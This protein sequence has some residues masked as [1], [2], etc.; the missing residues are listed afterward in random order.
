[1]RKSHNSFTLIELMV[2]MVVMGVL[3]ALAIPAFSR[4]ISGNKVD[5]LAS[6]LKLALE[7]AQSRAVTD[8]RHVALILPNRKN[9]DTDEKS[10]AK[11][12]FGGCRMAFVKH[13][14][15][16]TVDED[17]G[18]RSYAQGWHFLAWVPDSAWQPAI[19][20]V[21]LIKTSSQSAGDFGDFYTDG[22]G[23]DVTKTIAS[24]NYDGLQAI[25]GCDDVSSA[26]NCAV[27]FSPYG[28][29]AGGESLRLAVAEAER[30]G[31][32]FVFPSQDS[33][34]NPTDFRVLEVN[35]FTGRVKHMPT[36]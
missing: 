12:E 11:S 23:L 13:Q 4:M 24:V 18:V 16:M 7:Q 34:G 2:V 6:Q 36:Y 5:Q 28:G 25:H 29:V 21:V 30:N 32:N 22:A 31:S 35:R 3:A 8:R 10:A 33:S 27:I 26:E 1:M 19:P 15:K 9:R 17:T 14:G 20:G